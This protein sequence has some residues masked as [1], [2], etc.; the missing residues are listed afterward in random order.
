MRGRPLRPH[1]AHRL[2]A[3]AALLALGCVSAARNDMAQARARYEQ[4]VAASSERECR[5]EKEHK[6]AAERA[7][8]ESAQRAWGCDPVQADCPPR[9]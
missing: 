7:Y 3:L 8:Q 5:A 6:L 9:R 2:A 4:C 1:I